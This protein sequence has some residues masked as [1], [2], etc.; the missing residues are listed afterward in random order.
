MTR[1]ST[2][3]YKYQPLLARLPWCVG[4]HSTNRCI[5]SSSRAVRLFYIDSNMFGE[6]GN[7]ET[8]TRFAFYIR[9]FVR[10]WV[11]VP[12]G[13]AGSE[14]RLVEGP[15]RPPVVARH[16]LTLAAPIFTVFSN[17]SS[18]VTGRL[19]SSFT[20]LLDAP[21]HP[22][23]LASSRDTLRYFSARNR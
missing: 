14:L 7:K 16:S 22:R 17:W 8:K 18:S 19:A 20:R 5:L 2:P 10:A 12:S 9:V 11:P 23:P 4:A 6:S 21:T 13:G 1:Q 15:V 3:N